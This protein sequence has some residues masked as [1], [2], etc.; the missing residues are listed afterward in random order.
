MGWYIFHITYFGSVLVHPHG[1]I[2]SRFLKLYMDPSSNVD[3]I[4]GTFKGPLGGLGV[5]CMMAEQGS[6]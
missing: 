4:V 3:D 5:G 2:Q 6:C 1:C